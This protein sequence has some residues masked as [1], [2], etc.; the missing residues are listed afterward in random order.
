MW[1]VC[2]A[3]SS[4]RQGMRCSRLAPPNECLVRTARY[5]ALSSA[6]STRACPASSASRSLLFSA[7]NASAREFGAY[8]HAGRYCAGRWNADEAT[9]DCVVSHCRRPPAMDGWKRCKVAQLVCAMH[10]CLADPDAYVLLTYSH[11]SASGPGI[12]QRSCLCGNTSM[13][14][15][16]R[17]A[18]CARWLQLR[19]IAQAR[20]AQHY[21]SGE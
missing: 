10:A 8:D 9:H 18:C 21:H 3:R 6:T 1:E 14:R 15:Q 20:R 19:C 17:T 7:A 2:C 5:P 13:R 16:Q 11:E 12:L 4:S